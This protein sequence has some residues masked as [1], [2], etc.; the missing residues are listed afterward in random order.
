MEVNSTVRYRSELSNI[1]WEE[2]TNFTCPHKYIFESVK[3]PN[4]TSPRDFI[5]GRYRIPYIYNLY[6]GKKAT[7]NVN[8]NVEYVPL[9]SEVEGELVKS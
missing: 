4:K 5:R 7:C 8:V 9:S 6:G 1:S 3:K 2:P